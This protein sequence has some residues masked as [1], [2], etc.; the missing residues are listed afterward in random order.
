MSLSS[1]GADVLDVVSTLPARL[2]GAADLDL[3]VEQ[4]VLAVAF[5][6]GFRAPCGDPSSVADRLAEAVVAAQASVPLV[7][8]TPSAEQERSGAEVPR[9]RRFSGSAWKAGEGRRS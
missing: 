1:R 5:G 8:A 7:H 9:C 2:R 4:Y 6:Q 3:E